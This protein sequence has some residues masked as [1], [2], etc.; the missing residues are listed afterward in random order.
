MPNSVNAALW[1]ARWLGDIHNNHGAISNMEVS[2][3]HWTWIK[4][5]LLATTGAVPW[6]AA[7]TNSKCKFLFDWP[8]PG[9][10]LLHQ[11][12]HKPSVLSPVCEKTEQKVQ[13]HK[14]TKSQ[15]ITLR[16][17]TQT[18]SQRQSNCEQGQ[19]E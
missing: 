16:I 9:W 8:T 6:Y 1:R 15:G 2:F 11:G 19:Q 3:D 18:F 12:V 4:K 13:D 17:Y 5:L 10:L 14:E 7:F